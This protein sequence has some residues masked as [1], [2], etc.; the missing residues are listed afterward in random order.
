MKSVSIVLGKVFVL[1]GAHDQPRGE[2][3][4]GDGPSV[5]HLTASNEMNDFEHVAFSQS[6]C[7]KRRARDDLAIAFDRDL[8]WIE[9]EAA[10]QIGDKA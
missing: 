8:G 2:G 1:A 3:A 6:Y 4:T 9:F 10:D 5:G 7:A